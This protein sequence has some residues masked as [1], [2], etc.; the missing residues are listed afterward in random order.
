M[1]VA[2]PWVETTGKEAI[3]LADP[4][5]WPPALQA[6]LSQAG[7]KLTVADDVPRLL[8]FGTNTSLV[9]IAQE[10]A[11]DII[12]ALRPIPSFAE[13][14]ILVIAQTET[15]LALALEAGAND[16]VTVDGNPVI[17]AARIRA[18]LRADKGPEPNPVIRVRDLE[19]DLDSCRVTVLGQLVPLTPTEFRIIRTLA[20][21]GGRV[22]SAKTLLSGFQSYEY[23]DRDAQSL[24]KVHMANLRRKLAAAGA[25]DPYILCV[26]GFG[27][28]ME[29]RAQRREGDPLAELIDADE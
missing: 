6:A 1:R 9:I 10:N 28:M 5:L 7:L 26:R 21:N 19:I 4:T 27:Y 8:I 18:L 17:L 22:V 2:T 20:E 3:A 29:R 23:S 13:K 25:P 11:C 15:E 16:A 12:S 14:R 24:V